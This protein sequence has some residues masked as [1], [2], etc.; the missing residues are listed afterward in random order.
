MRVSRSQHKGQISWFIILGL[1][2]II[3]LLAYQYYTTKYTRIKPG[4][5]YPPE[6]Q[7]ITTY[8]QD[9]MRIIGKEATELLGSQ[10]GWISVPTFI[11]TD[12]RASLAIDNEGLRRIP[13]WHYQGE[14][15]VPSIP[16]MER[17][18]NTYIT[19]NL[20]TCLHNFS[21]LG[22]TIIPKGNISTITTIA[23]NDVIIQ[24][25]YPLAIIINP[26]KEI[27]IDTYEISLPVQLKKLYELAERIM[28]YENQHAFI[29]NLTIDLMST[30]HN[31]PFTNM[32][33][34]CNQRTWNINKIRDQLQTTLAH[35]FQ[36]IRIA[37]TNH[38]LFFA[39]RE[40]YE[41]LRDD[42][43]GIITDLNAGIEDIKESSHYPK[44]TP[45]DAFE[46]FHQYIDVG[47]HITNA[48]VAIHYS[49]E[50]GMYI[51][52][53][54]SQDGILKSTNMQGDNT[55]LPFLCLNA[56]HFTYDINY[57]VQVFLLDPTGFE[58]G[59]IFNFA[60][61]AQIQNN[62]ASRDE[63][64]YTT[65]E[66]IRPL[67]EG[68]CEQ[69]AN[70]M[71]EFRAVGID[72]EGFVADSGLDEVNI[73]YLC[74]GRRCNLG[75]TNALNGRYA[76]QTTLPSGC[77]HPSIIASK[78][79]YLSTQ[80]PLTQQEQILQLTKLKNLPV[81]IQKHQYFAE[82]DNTLR[83]NGED[84]DKETAIIHIKANNYNL[85]QTIMIPSNDTNINLIDSKADYTIDIVL[86][87]GNTIIGGYHTTNI[88]FTRD[89]IA[90]AGSITFHTFEYRPTPSTDTE[91]ASMLTYFLSETYK[92]TLTP[93]LKE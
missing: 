77:A 28:R 84:L 41:Q 89:A 23:E 83:T 85:D 39:P 71:H 47:S 56:W 90:S 14:N 52:A 43:Q 11:S 1:V 26:T 24:V 61:L 79:G 19:Q 76:L 7:P 25:R 38:T 75:T 40:T 65:K 33:F 58:N 60:F 64:V 5:L 35:N 45:P 62:A 46:Y 80:T 55:Y 50:F 74:A 48:K 30:N 27:L 66:D 34:N 88:T 2:V 21:D 93:E 8:I 70:T 73:S 68:F 91:Q 6:A 54:P 78:I 15:R 32:E 4:I 81:Q 13:Y 82:I 12:T 17:S 69:R 20:N 31:I 53:N 10:G 87:R 29:E 44:N 9:C 51:R 92:D 63:F 37:N 59:Y 3:T 57:P 86:S 42:Y 36:H 22:K 49:P 67:N 72:Q 18:I 16:G